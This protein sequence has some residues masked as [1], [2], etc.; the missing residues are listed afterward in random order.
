MQFRKHDKHV[1]SWR[2]SSLE[3][4]VQLIFNTSFTKK[5]MNSSEIKSLIYF[6]YSII[7][8]WVRFGLIAELN[9]WLEF[10]LVWLSS[11]KI[12]FDWVRF[13]MPGLLANSAF[14]G[15]ALFN[16]PKCCTFAKRCNIPQLLH[17]IIK[18]STQ[19]ERVWSL[20]QWSSYLL[21]SCFFLAPSSPHHTASNQEMTAESWRH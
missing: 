9:P 16:F 3:K 13:T 8:V 1:S 17:S 19:L 7:F 5:K 6:D 20:P 11:I 10:N 4:L 12:Q 14:S 15:E 18:V 2:N 21:P